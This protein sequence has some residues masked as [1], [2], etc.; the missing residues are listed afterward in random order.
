MQS[1]SVKTPQT[2]EENQFTQIIASYLAYWPLFVILLIISFA[3]AFLYLRYTAPVYQ[4]AAKLIIKDEKKGESD[5]KGVES[6]D[7]IN[8]KKIIEN[9]IEVLQSRVLI[10]NVV[11]KLHLYAPLFQE[12]DIHIQSAYALS[13]IV[14]ESKTPESIKGFEKILLQYDKSKG[15][16]TLNNSFSGPINEW[17]KTPYGELKFTNN[18][19]FYESNNTKPIFFNLI[20]IRKISSGIS[21]GLKVNASSKLSS[22]IDLSYSDEVPQ[23]AE[24][25][26]NALIYFY[27]ES[28]VTEKSNLVKN[29]LASIEER[30]AVVSHD[31]DSIE[32]K[33]QQFT[34]GNSAVS[35]GTQ[36]NLYLQSVNTTDAKLGEVNVQLSNLNQLEKFVTAKGTNIGI[37]PSAIGVT[38]PTLTQLMSN[39][40]NTQMEYEK[41]KKTVGENNPIL[42][43]LKEQIE[44]IKPTILSNIQ[45]QK[46]NLESSRGNL[47]SSTG[48]YSS[49]LNYIPQKERQLIEISR[50][51][52]IKSNIYQFLLQKREESE[53]SYASTLSDSKVVNYAQAGREPVSPKKMIIYLASLLCGLALPILLINSREMLNNKILYRK[54]I[55]TLTDLPIIGEVVFNKSSEQLVLTAGKRSFIA[56]EFR[57]I[58]ISLLYLGIDANH[59]KIA[60]TSSIPGEGKSFIAANLAVSI[61][62]TGKKVALVDMDLHNPSLGKIF[63]VST[64]EVGVSEYLNGE[65]EVTEIIRKIPNQNNLSYLSSGG[66]QDTPSELLENGK[67]QQLISYLEDNFDVIILDTPPVVMVTDAYLLSSLSDATLYIVRH[68]Y[69]PKMLVKRIDETNKIN[70]LKNAAIIFNGIKTRGFIENNYGYGYDY[71]Y[72]GDKKST[73]LKNT[74][75]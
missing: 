33:V 40:N 74:K 47:S 67:I 36:S 30:L 32:R 54:E 10:N 35:L 62:M 42:L 59:K 64:K 57:K 22:V 38:D 21:A 7:I 69:T 19:Y 39:L 66:L 11:K 12:G 29:A 37:L 45:T 20:A 8:T 6:I 49:M 60:V 26:L 41:Q 27:N 25:I 34:A 18:P 63:N 17:V 3:S 51:R 52:Q 48:K 68:K 53:L 15:K 13:P 75:I 72:G 71:V 43:S 44:N 73:N 58:R 1:K 70:S 31:L 9:E 61:A 14:V 56:E 46:R 16:I 50:D 2:K 24:D 65:K 5:S 23:R 4:A 55:E 28:G